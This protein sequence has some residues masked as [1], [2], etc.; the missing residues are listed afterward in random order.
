MSFGKWLQRTRM[1][2]GAYGYRRGVGAA[3]RTFLSGVAHRASGWGTRSDAGD[4]VYDRE[5]DAVVVLDACR[6][7][8]LQ[9]VADEYEFLP[10]DVPAIRS[11]APN[12][13]RWMRRTFT[14]AYA[15]EISRTAYVSANTHTH[16]FAEGSYPVAADDFARLEEVWRHGLDD[17]AGTVPP[18]AVT[19]R[20]IGTARE[21][22]PERLVVHYMQPHTP[23]RSLDTDSLGVPDEKQFRETVWDLR[24]AGVLTDEEVWNAYL[25]NLRWALD[26]VALLLE[27]LDAE[28]VVLTADHGECFGEWGAYGHSP[29]GRFDVL[30]RVPWVETTATDERTRRSADGARATE[31]ADPDAQLA[32]LGYR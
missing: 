8:A 2:V 12:S 31:N 21:S 14:P 7:D 10:D 19:D 25:D 22:N 17:D 23:Y 30:R 24:H 16:G 15:D 28:R 1:Q 5:W 11:V 3:V 9:S 4:P 18:R 27:N 32:A 26:D 13:E 20:A 6:V 29:Q